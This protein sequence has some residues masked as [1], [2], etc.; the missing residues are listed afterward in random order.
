VSADQAAAVSDLE[1]A[2][3]GIVEEP[4][5]AYPQGALAGALV[6]FSNIDGVGARGI[7]QMEDGWLA[8]RGQ[9]VAVERDARGRLL[10]F[11]DYDP[12]SSAGGDGALP[13]RGAL[14]AEAQTAPGAAG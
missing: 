4:R 1:L 12:R 13:P 7:E 9:R 2:G 11:A 10:A 5:R 14:H 8:G 3:V 6:G